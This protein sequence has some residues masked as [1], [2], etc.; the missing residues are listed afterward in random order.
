MSQFEQFSQGLRDQM[1]NF[2]E[3]WQ[4][5]WRKARHAMTRFTPASQGSTEEQTNQR[6]GTSSKALSASANIWS[7]LS[8]E[9]SETDNNIVVQLEAP[10]MSSEDFIITVDNLTLSIRGEKQY[11]QEH[12]QGRYHISER[13]YGRFERLLPLPARV[14]EREVKAKYRQGVLTVTLPKIQAATSRRIEVT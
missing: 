8:A 14:S 3:G 10:G 7:V 9:V 1:D 2:T 4:H 13:A 6:E 5:M 12:D 11:E